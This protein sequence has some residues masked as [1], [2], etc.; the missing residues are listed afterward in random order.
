MFQLI[1]AVIS[2]ALIAVL[3]AAAIFYG[4]SAF[5][6]NQV[7]AMHAKYSNGALQIQSAMDYY[8]AERIAYPGGTSEEKMTALIDNFYLES[9]P[10]GAWII[11]DDNRT[12]SRPMEVSSLQACVKLNQY[13]GKPAECP[14]CAESEPEDFPA[15]VN[16]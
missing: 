7:R 9:Q 4:G 15:C 16:P 5:S 6:E 12:I 8:K 14:P 11:S 13:A 3:A 2:I 1:I 10:E